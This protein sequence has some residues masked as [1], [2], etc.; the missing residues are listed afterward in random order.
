MLKTV[1][2]LLM[3]LLGASL[4]LFIF[5]NTQKSSHQERMESL[6]ELQEEVEL[7]NQIETDLSLE[8][9]FRKLDSIKLKID[10]GIYEL[11]NQD[12]Y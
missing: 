12:P 4:F 5:E 3:I 9:S 11:E 7:Y 2:R 6:K 1:I 8:R 10:S